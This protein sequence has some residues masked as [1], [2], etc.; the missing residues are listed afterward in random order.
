[1][2]AKYGSIHAAKQKLGSVQDIRRTF[3]EFQEQ[4][5]EE[6]AG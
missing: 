3:I 1:M 6:L 5:Y 4:L 2:N